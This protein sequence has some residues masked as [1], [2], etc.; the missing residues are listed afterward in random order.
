MNI[1]PVTD[2]MVDTALSK[3]AYMLTNTDPGEL[4]G[5]LAHFVERIEVE[6]HELTFFYSFAKPVAGI[7]PTTGDPEGGWGFNFPKAPRQVC[8]LSV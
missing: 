7:M 6:G 4:K 2:A 8:I 1:P 5:T 3:I